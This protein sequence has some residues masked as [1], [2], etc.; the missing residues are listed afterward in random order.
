MLPP[1]QQEALPELVAQQLARRT[2]VA[3]L[4]AQKWDF[5]WSRVRPILRTP[6]PISAPVLQQHPRKVALLQV[7]VGQQVEQVGLI[8]DLRMNQG[9]QREDLQ[10]FPRWTLESTL[11]G[12]PE[13]RIVKSSKFWNIGTP[14]NNDSESNASNKEPAADRGLRRSTRKYERDQGQVSIHSVTNS[15]AV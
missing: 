6:A 1:L 14:K 10:E 5:P 15:K 4:E 7:E 12:Y 3:Q 8:P 13:L 11:D 2:P 9:F